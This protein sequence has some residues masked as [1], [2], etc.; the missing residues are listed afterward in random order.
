ML[1]TTTSN[2]AD[3]LPEELTGSRRTSNDVSKSALMADPTGEWRRRS[4]SERQWLNRVAA[5]TSRSTSAADGDAT[6]DATRAPLADNVARGLGWLS[7]APSLGSPAAKAASPGKEALASFALER[8]CIVELLGA[9]NVPAMALG[10]AANSDAPAESGAVGSGST[11]PFATMAVVSGKGSVAWASKERRWPFKR[12]T[13]CPAWHKA[14]DLGSMRDGDVL[15]VALHHHHD[16]KANP[17]ITSIT[18]PRLLSFAAAKP[19]PLSELLGRADF[20]LAGVEFLKV[21]AVALQPAKGATKGPPT[22]VSLRFLPP[23]NA[24][25]TVFIVR[26][27]ER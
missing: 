2:F 24:R 22:I 15:R 25:K 10:A 9:T 17:S 27:A 23:R 1:G 14:R 4:Q 21:Y 5:R 11:N 3:V 8:P 26:H 18:R 13:C 19:Q 6:T 7:R 16:G 12:D 20:P